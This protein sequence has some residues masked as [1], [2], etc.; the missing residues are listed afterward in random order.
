MPV[1]VQELAPEIKELRPPAVPHRRGV[2]VRSAGWRAKHIG[3]SQVRRCCRAATA[4]VCDVLLAVSSRHGSFMFFYGSNTSLTAW[5]A[6][7]GAAEHTLFLHQS[8][9]TGCTCRRSH[10]RRAGELC[11][12]IK[13]LLLVCCGV[14]ARSICFFI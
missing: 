5:R 11:C 3:A 1:T 13:V 2:C 6:P 4:F 7:P 12:K 10:L 8:R 9:K 14:G